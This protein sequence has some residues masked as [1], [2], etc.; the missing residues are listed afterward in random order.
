MHAVIRS[1]GEGKRIVT[2]KWKWGHGLFLKHFVGNVVLRSLWK[3]RFLLF[4]FEN[5]KPVWTDRLFEFG[6]LNFSV[7][8]EAF[9]VFIFE[10][11]VEG[12]IAQVYFIAIALIFGCFLVKFGLSPFL[13]F[14]MLGIV[15]AFVSFA[16]HGFVMVSYNVI[17]RYYFL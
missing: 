2:L 8:H 5:F 14:R 12:G 17:I 11:E 16:A 15:F 1:V 10:M 13:F 6:D 3:L 9:R 4:H 7:V